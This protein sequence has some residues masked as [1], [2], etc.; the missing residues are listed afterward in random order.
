MVMF[1]V[2]FIIGIIIYMDLR[3]ISCL[4]WKILYVVELDLNPL[5]VYVMLILSYYYYY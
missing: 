5:N 3:M 1:E 2:C 4:S